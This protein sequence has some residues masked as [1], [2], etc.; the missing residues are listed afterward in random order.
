MEEEEEEATWFLV[1]RLIAPSLVSLMAQISFSTQTRTSNYPGAVATSLEQ[2][3][4]GNE[5]Q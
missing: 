1:G 2:P 3:A 4:L 5:Q